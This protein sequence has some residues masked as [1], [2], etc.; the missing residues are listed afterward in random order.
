M[1]FIGIIPSRYA[2]TRFPGKPLADIGGKMMIQR[3]YEQSSKVL[4]SVVVATDDQRIEQAVKNF[5]GKV[6]MT[7]PNHRSGTDRCCEAVKNFE[8]LSGLTFDVVINI[9]GDE[10][11]IHPEQIQELMSCFDDETT[12]IAT[13]VKEVDENEEIFDVNLPKVILNK[14]SEAIYFSR[15]PIPYVR[16]VEQDKWMEK[17]TF[18]KHIGIYAYRLDILKKITQLPPSSL[19]IAESLEQ[20]RWLENGYKIKVAETDYETVSV[21]TPDD[22]E[23]MKKLGLL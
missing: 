15:S 8:T 20:N 13:L 2:S 23:K 1:N 18:F 5:G 7:S 17:H 21:D 9:Q 19:E 14:D 22:I 16:N 12:Q 4:P 11:F 6:V 3:V 10:P